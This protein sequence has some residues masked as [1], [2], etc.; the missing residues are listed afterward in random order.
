MDAYIVSIITRCAALRRSRLHHFLLEYNDNEKSCYS[1]ENHA[2]PIS[3]FRLL[4]SSV[5]LLSLYCNVDFE[6]SFL[7]LLWSLKNAAASVWQV[8]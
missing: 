5:S 6:K 1:G 7:S 3:G 2:W 8:D 4:H